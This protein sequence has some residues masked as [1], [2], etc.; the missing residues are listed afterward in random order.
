[1]KK[2]SGYALLEVVICLGFALIFA[3]SIYAAFESA[4]RVNAKAREKLRNEI[5]IQNKVEEL[6][7]NRIDPGELDSYSQMLD[8]NTGLLVQADDQGTYY[9]ITI[10]YCKDS[11]EEEPT[12]KAEFDE[13]KVKLDNIKVIKK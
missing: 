4:A 5:A 3:F 9:L 7:A 8:T 11:D 6:L 13:Q 1:M 12:G 2:T 10:G